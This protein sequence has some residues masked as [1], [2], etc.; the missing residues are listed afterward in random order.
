MLTFK[1]KEQP[2]LH[3]DR[4]YQYTSHGFKSRIDG[5]EMIHRMSRVSQYIDNGPK[6]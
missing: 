5:T 4:G 2:L 3:S 1:D 6:E